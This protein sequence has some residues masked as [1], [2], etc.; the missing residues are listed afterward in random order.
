MK[1]NILTLLYGTAF[2]I[3]LAGAIQTVMTIRQMPVLN[4]KLR[5]RADAF[6]QLCALEKIANRQQAA[7]LSFESLTNV[8]PVSL[9]ALTTASV[10]NAMPE[11]RMR[12]TRSLF[13]GWMLK[14][15]EIIFNDV[16]LDQIPGF[17]EA[18]ESSRPPWRLTECRITATRSEG[19]FG[20][21][22]LVME[23]LSK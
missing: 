19:G 14:E 5:S 4:Q 11:I 6:Q 8:F 23:A 10:T 21:I 20:R 9:T 22:V 2:L 16:N 12:D 18:A 1:R 7:I 15:V 13:N 3:L 17:L